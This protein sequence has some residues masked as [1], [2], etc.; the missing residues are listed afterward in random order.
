MQT[1][2]TIRLAQQLLRMKLD[3]A[4]Y[5][6]DATAGNGKDTL[7]LAKHSPD[8]AVIWS[9]DVQATAI[10]HTGCLLQKHGLMHKV[11]LIHDSHIHIASYLEQN[12][13]LD[14][15]MFNLGYLP[16][17]DHCV[18]TRAQD[19]VLALQTVVQRLNCGGVVSIVAYRGHEAGREEE[20]GIE[21][22][23][24]AL[25]AAFFTVGHW[26]MLNHA[27]H[28][29]VLYMVEKV[30]GGSSERVAARQD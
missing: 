17:G 6:V 4:R 3:Q 10:D 14:I 1:F 30:R 2:S 28:S 7:F 25:P 8:S 26:T 12:A 11:R 16:G 23:L 15:V 19:T 29:P 18:T 24:A 13:G 21:A 9:F 22:L 20:Q 5:L 27:S